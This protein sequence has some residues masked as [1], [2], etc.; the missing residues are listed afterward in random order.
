MFF[1][2]SFA[3]KFGKVNQFKL[4]Y[5]GSKDGFKSKDFHRL[6]DGKGKTLGLVKTQA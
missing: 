2:N 1:S 5:R 6:C 4:I 3:K